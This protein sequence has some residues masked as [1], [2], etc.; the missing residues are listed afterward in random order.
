[1]T[2][3]YLARCD[4]CGRA[5]DVNREIGLPDGWFELTSSRVHQ[6]RS[7]MASGSPGEQ[8]EVLTGEFCSRLCIAAAAV[9]AEYGEAE[10]LKLHDIA[11]GAAA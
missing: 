9:A 10:A 3:E 6:F 2:F 4:R 5:A 8:D 7:A 11:R 1:M